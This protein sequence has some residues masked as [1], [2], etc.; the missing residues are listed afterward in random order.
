MDTEHAT[1]FAGVSRAV[2]AQETRLAVKTETPAA[3][4]ALEN[5]WHE[6]PEVFRA[7]V[8]MPKVITAVAFVS[9]ACFVGCDAASSVRLAF[10][11]MASG[12]QQSSGISGSVL[13]ESMSSSSEY[14][15][16]P[17]GATG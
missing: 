2:F 16:Q 12:P 9:F 7:D 8:A 14:D 17:V 11:I 1:H 13:S 4:N 3:S 15:F 6:S 5:I 10:A